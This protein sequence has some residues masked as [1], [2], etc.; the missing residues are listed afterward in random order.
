MEFPTAR[1]TPLRW[2]VG[3]V[4]GVYKENL[5]VCVAK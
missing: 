4:N 1:C 5:E 2:R 3:Q